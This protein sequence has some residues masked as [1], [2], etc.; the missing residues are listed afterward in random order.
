MEFVASKVGCVTLCKTVC[1]CDGRHVV[2]CFIDHAECKT[3]ADCPADVDLW[4]TL[5]AD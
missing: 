5:F 3:A 4:Y 2:P 1:V